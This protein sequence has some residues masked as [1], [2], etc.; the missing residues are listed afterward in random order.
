MPC[1]LLSNNILVAMDENPFNRTA[2]LVACLGVC[3][4]GGSD[5]PLQI[6]QCPCRNLLNIDRFLW[7]CLFPSASILR[8]PTGDCPRNKFR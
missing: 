4:G 3:C 2:P 1:F 5:V 7:P 8:L 6:I